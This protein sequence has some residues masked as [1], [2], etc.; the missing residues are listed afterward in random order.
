LVEPYGSQKYI[1]RHE[2]AKEFDSIADPA[3]M[4]ERKCFDR[5]VYVVDKLRDPQVA[6]NETWLPP[7]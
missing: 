3:A 4:L 5:I 6:C 1:D 7:V 2:I